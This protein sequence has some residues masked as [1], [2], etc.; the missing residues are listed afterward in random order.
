MSQVTP[1]IT[2]RTPLGQLH[3]TTPIISE[4]PGFAHEENIKSTMNSTTSAPSNEVPKEESEYAKT[5]KNAIKE[6]NDENNKLKERIMELEALLSAGQ[7]EIEQKDK[8]ILELA[9][10]LES[11]SQA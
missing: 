11:K 2:G 1:R 10:L 5:L 8:A 3:N 6:A 9:D 4:K 7:D